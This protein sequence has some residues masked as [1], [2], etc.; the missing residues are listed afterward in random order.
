MIF[1][2]DEMFPPATVGY[3]EELG[4]SAVAARPTGL[5]TDDLVIAYATEHRLVI[6][7]ENFPDFAHVTTCT[8]LF[9]SKTSLPR[10][11]A[12]AAALARQLDRWA[13]E[14]PDPPHG[15]LWLKA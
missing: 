5:A 8:V 4:H 14:H 12:M 9:A 13:T 10:G 3:L 15:P 11:G 1:L 2:I 7:T 6:V